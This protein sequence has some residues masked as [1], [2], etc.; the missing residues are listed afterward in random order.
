MRIALDTNCFIDLSKEQ[1]SSHKAMKIVEEAWRAGNIKVFV[2]R[3]SLSELERKPDAALDF[4]RQ[5]EILPHYPIGCYNEQVATYDQ[6]EGTW[7]N[8]KENQKKQCFLKKLAKSGNDIRD[9]GA[10][11][12][13]VMAG[14][15]AFVTSDQ[16][17]ADSEVAERIRNKFDL[18]VLTPVD[19][20]DQL[21]DT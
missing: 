21:E 1:S 18:Q 13:A 4:A 3:Y 20:A 14:I 19:L 5:A 15:D 6:C 11:L 16:H 17:L 2:S 7:T 12:D 10:Y 8:A 9:R